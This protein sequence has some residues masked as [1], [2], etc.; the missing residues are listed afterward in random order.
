VD[1]YRELR[2]ADPGNQVFIGRIAELLA[3]VPEKSDGVEQLNS[4]AVP[5]AEEIS[6]SEHVLDTLNGWL[7]NIKGV[8]ECRTKIL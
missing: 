8:R 6:G 3:P 4:S 5:S 1:V 7:A 2:Q